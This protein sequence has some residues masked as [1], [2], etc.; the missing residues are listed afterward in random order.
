M[1]RVN[2]YQPLGFTMIELL[3]VITIIGVMSA[4]IVMNVRTKDPRQAMQKEAVRMVSVFRV[5][6]DEAA[7]QQMEIGV[8]VFDDGYRFLRWDTGQLEALD[9]AG[10]LGGTIEDQGDEV[11]DAMQESLDKGTD[12]ASEVPEA[13]WT[14][15][16]N[17]RFLKAHDLPDG[18][19]IY[20]TVDKENIDT[21]TKKDRKSGDASQ[22]SSDKGKTSGDDLKPSIYFLSS[23][24][25]TPFTL[26]MSLEGD[27]D[28]PIIIEGDM[29]SRIWEKGGKDDPDRKDTK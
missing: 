3:V 17:Q 19:R 25:A 29:Q 20:L 15:I 23:G 9:E 24:E 5:A 4:A 10:D 13:A 7:F 11:A 16:E 18:I 14:V 28:D 8:E 27:S 26:E 21:G 2:R 12:E 6:A 22:T 1:R